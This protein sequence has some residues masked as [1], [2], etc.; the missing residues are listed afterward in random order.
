MAASDIFYDKNVLTLKSV[1]WLPENSM[2]Q[3]W[4]S[5]TQK[6]VI[7]YEKETNLNGDVLELTFVVSDSA[8][9]G[10]YSIGLACKM[11][12][13]GEQKTVAV[14]EGIITVKN[15]IRGD[16]DGDG[17]VTDRDAIYLLYNVYFP[18]DFPIYQTC[19]FDNDGEVTD[20]DA[21]YLLYYV[22]FPED[23]PV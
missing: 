15:Y 3:S 23:F 16:M 9:D 7:L 22:Y 19:D 20:R 1:K 17:E 13:N 10:E 4:S 5:T 8:E 6:G 12:E 14:K 18:E 21:I 2:V 11:T